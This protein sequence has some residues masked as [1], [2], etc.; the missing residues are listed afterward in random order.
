MP[1]KDHLLSQIL[2]ESRIIRHLATKVTSDDID[3][4]PSEAQ[5][6]TLDLM[7]Y[8][9]TCAMVPAKAGVT[10]NWEHAEAI[11]KASKSVTPETFDS[12]MEDQENA[13]KAI[14]ETI[15]EDDFENKNAVLPW[16]PTKKLGEAMI[17][18]ALK[19][20]VAYRMQ[21]FLYLKASSHPELNSANCWIGVDPQPPSEE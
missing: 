2:E 4:R 16:G 17:V 12:A 3:Y 6:S 10:G 20:L 9:T 15:T 21:F 8:L 11:E 1:A 19:P 14:F 13:L 7:R 18:L 5:R